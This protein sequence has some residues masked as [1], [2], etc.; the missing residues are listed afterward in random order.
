MTRLR[1]TGRAPSVNLT[2]LRTIVEAWF[3][4]D[5]PTVEQI[6]EQ[7]GIC[8]ATVRKYLKMALGGLPRGR[9]ACGPREPQNIDACLNRVPTEALLGAGR[10]EL[11]RRKRA[12]GE[13]LTALATE[14]GISRDRVTK[15]VRSMG[16]EPEAAAPEAQPEAAE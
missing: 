9:A 10:C 16:V 7:T 2:S 6:A 13:S 5:G 14:F 8:A 3:H 12:Q 4:K 1:S 15:L 11:L